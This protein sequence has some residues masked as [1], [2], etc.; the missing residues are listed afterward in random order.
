[1]TISVGI[2]GL[3]RIGRQ[4]LKLCLENNEIDIVGINELNPD[5]G[6]WCYTLNYDSI[7][8]Q[9]FQSKPFFTYQGSKLIKDKIE[10]F[11]SHHKN[12]LDIPWNSWGADYV[13]DCTGVSANVKKSKEMI[14]QHG[15]KNV[16]ISHSPPIDDVDMTMI[17][18]ANHEDY[19]TNLHQVIASS[20]CDATAIAPVTKLIDD[21]F[22]IISGYVTTLHPW[23][24]YQ[25][26]LDGPSSSWSV[27]GEIYHHYALGRSA[28]NNIIPKPTSA[29]DAVFKVLPQLNSDK[30]G[31]FSYRMPTS[32]VA[33]ADIT[34]CVDKS[35]SKQHLLDLF[36]EFQKNQEFPVVKLE[37]SPLT[38]VDYAGES[39]SCIVDLR[40]LDIVANS[41]IKIVL[42]YDNE[43]GYSSNVVRQLLYVAGKNSSSTH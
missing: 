37:E 9:A 6:N 1:M 42:W 17:I 27:P 19:D 16:F 26:L 38:S 2:N 39:C 3:G 22:N 14:M 13:I 10:I 31:S 29:L 18:G 5:I 4:V 15:I 33:S 28:I 7:Y 21:N 36:E 12:C 11:T 20:I 40:W 41:M 24:S 25:N 43:Y 23:L 35:V 30:I 32:I 8:P 34:Y